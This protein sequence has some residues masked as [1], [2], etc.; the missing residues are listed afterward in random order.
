MPFRLRVACC[1]KTD[2]PPPVSAT[3]RQLHT[4]AYMFTRHKTLTEV[5]G[6]NRSDTHQKRVCTDGRRSG[7]FGGP[8]VLSVCR[9]SDPMLT[10][11]GMESY[12]S[13]AP[14]GETLNRLRRAVSQRAFEIMRECDLGPRIRSRS[15]GTATNCRV[16]Y[17]TEP[18]LFATAVSKHASAALWLPTPV[19]LREHDGLVTILSPAE[20][21]VRD[22]AAL[23]GLQ[24]LVEQS[25]KALTEAL[26]SV[27]V[28]TDL[29][30]QQSEYHR[31]FL[32]ARLSLRRR[33]RSRWRSGHDNLGGSK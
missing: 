21:I 27:G 32:W 26:N 6:S 33:S 1:A 23:L 7:R 25:Y 10:S 8:S 4:F 19:V 5:L 24:C 20:A 15:G 13:S 14:Y 9:P 17:V 28:P 30:R 3:G 12:N 16:L 2:C 18:D 11:A 31:V 29:E 22:R